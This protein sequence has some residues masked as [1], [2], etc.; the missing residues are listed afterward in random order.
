MKNTVYFQFSSFAFF[1]DLKAAVDSAVA[2][3]YKEI[4]L[5][6]AKAKEEK[7][8]G[9]SS[10][11]E[12][13]LQFL[14]HGQMMLGKIRAD[15]SLIT[16]ESTRNE[17][18]KNGGRFDVEIDKCILPALPMVIESIQKGIQETKSQLAKA[19]HDKM[20][21]TAALFSVTLMQ[22]KE[23]LEMFSR[24]HVQLVAEGK[25]AEG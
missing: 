24:V 17:R 14:K 1:D 7:D 21:V 18:E 11:S 10:S 12:D 19:R 9:A 3:A 2:Q 5:L 16:P 20:S 8:S 15:L 6:A 4:G 13:A 23:H 25:Q 22:A